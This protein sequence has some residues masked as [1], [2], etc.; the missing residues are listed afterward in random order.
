[1]GVERAELQRQI[2]SSVSQLSEAHREILVLQ[3]FH[4]LT[5]REIAEALSIPQG[6][7]MSRLHAARI[8]L[9]GLLA[10]ERHA[11]D[12]ADDDRSST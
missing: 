12:V 6:T 8:S 2:W 11:D 4:G 3:N 7:V 5:Y 9:R 1:M 10:S